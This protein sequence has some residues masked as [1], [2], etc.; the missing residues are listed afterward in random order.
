MYR[1]GRLNYNQALD[2]ILRVLEIDIVALDLTSEHT[3]GI[4]PEGAPPID[5][6]VVCYDSS[7]EA[8]FDQVEPVLRKHLVHHSRVYLMM[9][10]RLG[11][12]S[13]APHHCVRLQVRPGLSR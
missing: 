10:S 5:G 4:V 12:T 3:H 1:V 6:V 2:R 8:S 11:V 7:E 13:E 9:F